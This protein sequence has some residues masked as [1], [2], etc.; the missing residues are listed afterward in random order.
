[1]ARSAHPPRPKRSSRT[2]AENGAGEQDRPRQTQRS[3]RTSAENAA[4]PADP[5]R[6]IHS[7]RTSAAKA[8]RAARLAEEMRK[9]L[10][11]RKAQQ[12]AKRE[13]PRAP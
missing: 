12:R 9:N 5:P 6:P 2:S 3:A 4:R 13:K 10:L 1:M 11:K 8:A 7:P